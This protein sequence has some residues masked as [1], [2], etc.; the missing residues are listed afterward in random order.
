MN[1]SDELIKEYNSKESSELI[2]ILY[3]YHKWNPELIDVIKKELE[4]RNCFPIDYN[5]KINGLIQEEKTILEK[6]LQ[7]SLTKKIIS[8]LTIFGLLGIYVG[9]TFENSKVKSTYTN[10]EYLKYCEEDRNFGKYIFYLSIAI[11]FL[12]LFSKIR[13]F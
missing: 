6:G 10:L 1:L 13:N 9:Y 3:E 8:C 2:E 11:S 12:G 4:K 5:D 7:I